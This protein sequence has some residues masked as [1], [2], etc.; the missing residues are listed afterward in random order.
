MVTILMLVHKL[1]FALI[2]QSAERIHGKDEVTGPIPVEGSMKKRASL[3]AML[4]SS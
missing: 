2:A 4:V 3:Y 1:I